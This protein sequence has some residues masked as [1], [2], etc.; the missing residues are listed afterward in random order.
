MFYEKKS[1]N[2]EYMA[3]GTLVQ[4]SYIHFHNE[5]EMII[6]MGRGADAN[7][8]INT[9]KYSLSNYMDA[10]IITPG[11]IHSFETLHKGLFFAFI[12]PAEYIPRLQNVLTNQCPEN[13]FLNIRDI[14]AEEVLMDFWSRNG[15]L[16]ADIKHLRTSLLVGYLN[17]LMSYIYLNLNFVDA[18]NNSDIVKKVIVY[19]T[20]NYTEAISLTDLSEKF[21]LPSSLI[22]KQFNASTGITVPSFLNWLRVSKAAEMLATTSYTATVISNAVGF[23]TIRNFNRSFAEFY[24]ITP[25]QYR[26]THI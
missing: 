12:F 11:Q 16:P 25:S 20:E 23:R 2:L 18:N 9:K 14:G 15:Q 3:L 7:V 24:G 13:P 17:I 4:P 19:L 1:R 6:N 26:K 8:F 5:V 10:I 22:S 21:N